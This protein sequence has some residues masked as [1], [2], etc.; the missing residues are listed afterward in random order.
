LVGA[1][2][3]FSSILTSVSS[4]QQQISSSLLNV[5]AVYATTGSNSFRANQS[6]TGSL[7]VTGQIVAQSLNVQQV[8]SSIV[9]SSGS[10][11]FGCD[12]NSRQTFT[13][14]VIMTGSLTVNT[15]G[16]ELQVNNNGVIL[17]NLLTDN[18]SITGSLRITSS[19]NHYI[20]G[21]NLGLG[22]AP[23]PWGTVFTKSAFQFG[24]SVGVGA[25]WT[26]SF[27]NGVFLGNNL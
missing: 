4:S 1:S 24:G 23:S 21:G 14:S 9:F 27:N 20:M 16:T 5:I 2:A 13:G 10:N 19:G 11:T 7:T 18:H 12:L 15:T 3:S 6:I 8:T 22:V 17:G 26:N 25:L